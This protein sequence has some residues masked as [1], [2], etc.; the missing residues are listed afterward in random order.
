MTCSAKM[1]LKARV[2]D[3]YTTALSCPRSEAV[4]LN[5]LKYFLKTDYFQGI[6]KDVLYVSLKAI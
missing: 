4:F 1:H 5:S 3:A 6:W 2:L